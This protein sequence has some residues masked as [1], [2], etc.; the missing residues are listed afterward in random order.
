MGNRDTSTSA[1]LC[2]YLIFETQRQIAAD[3]GHNVTTIRR[4]NERSITIQKYING[5][6]TK[7]ERTN[8]GWRAQY[9]VVLQILKCF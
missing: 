8:N 6:K 4:Q 7:H 2:M 1:Y 5:F 9:Q 3:H